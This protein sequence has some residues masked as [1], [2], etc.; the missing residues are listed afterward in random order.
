MT[1]GS[2]PGMLTVIEARVLGCLLEKQRTTPE[3]YPLTL[4][5]LVS[6]CNQTTS[7]E[8]VMR[9]D[10]DEVTG[11][12]HSLKAAGVVRFVHPSHGRSVVRYRQVTDEA[13]SLDPAEAAVLALLLLRGPQT[14]A[15]LRARVD[16]LHDAASAD[17]VA[18]VLTRLEVA[19]RAE[20]VDRRHGQKEVRWRQLVAEEPSTPSGP[21]VME[22]PAVAGS[23]ADRLTRLEA[24]LSR[25][26]TALGDLLDGEVADA[27]LRDGVDP[28]DTATSP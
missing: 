28:T 1:V 11:A 10:E 15:E 8:P 18:A 22:T 23:L 25:I 4:N 24:R 13:W 12:L 2:V 3:Q 16:R 9:L 5:A 26:E 21:V 17:E 7:R 14:V 20:L 6:A 27:A 19:G